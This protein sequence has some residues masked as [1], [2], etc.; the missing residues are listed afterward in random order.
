AGGVPARDRPRSIR[1]QP[2]GGVPV[3]GPAL[4]GAQ[5]VRRRGRPRAGPQSAHRPLAADSELA[6]ATAVLARAQQDAV[7]DRTCAHNKLRSLLREYYPGLLAAF[8]D[9]RG[10]LLRPEA[11]L[12]LAAAATPRE[13][14]KLTLTQL[15]ALLKRAGRQRGLD[16]E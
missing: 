10:G 5:E 2:A 7:W 4:R 15:R 14:A 8:A 16:A 3:P 9:K 11:R 6:Q 12:L 1:D 13:A